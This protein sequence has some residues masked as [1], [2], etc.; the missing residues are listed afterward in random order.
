[1][2]N[3][4]ENEAIIRWLEGELSDRDLKE[5]L[6]EIDVLA[7][8]QIID[9]VDNWVPD[10][11]EEVFDVRLITGTPKQQEKQ[12]ETRVRRLNPVSY[13]SIAAS[14]VILIVAGFFAL[15][16]INTTT[17]L[18]DNKPMEIVLPDGQSKVILSPGSEITWTKDDWNETQRSMEITGKAYFDVSKGSPFTVKN[19]NGQVEV[20]GTQFEVSGFDESFIVACY[21]GKVMATAMNDQQLI[22][23]AGEESHYFDGEWA[24]KRP[25]NGGNPTWLQSFMNFESVDLKEVI[26]KLEKTYDI[27]IITNKV[28]INQKFSGRVPTDDLDVALNVTFD[29]FNISYELKDSTLYLDNK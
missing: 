29:V 6:P 20:L 19:S 12:E 8:R 23:T 4:E 2:R 7:Y 24:E 11:E 3:T 13:L 27:R 25:T 21:E 26:A 1:M 9:E 18:A 14:V 10:H 22:L 16:Y 28:D 17:H 5:I 15:E